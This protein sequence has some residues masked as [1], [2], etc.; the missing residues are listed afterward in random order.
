MKRHYSLMLFGLLLFSGCANSATEVISSTQPTETATPLPPTDTPEPTETATPLPP[1]NTPEPTATATTAYTPTPD[2]PKEWVEVA[3]EDRVI[4]G[5]LVGEGDIAVVL[6][7]MF[8]QSLGSWAHFADLIAPL[9][10]S[11]LAFDFPG[12]FGS[13][14]G[15]F[16]FDRV[17]FDVLAVI[18]FLRERG[19]ERIV[20]MGASIGADACFKA[21]QIDPSLAGLVVISSPVEA[22]AEETAILLMPKLFVASDDDEMDVEGPLKATYQLLP[23]PK[24]F[25]FINR[26]GHGTA[27]LNTGDELRDILVDFLENLR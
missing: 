22:N 18:N 7:P 8:G 16:K 25:E 20:C 27:L 3:Y 10:F 23:A 6:A 17:Q 12:P 11:A 5:T 14:S 1:T 9:G 15:E 4:K 19:Y 21:A 26:K 2:I 13:S 24:Q